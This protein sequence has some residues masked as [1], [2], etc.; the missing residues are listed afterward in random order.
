MDYFAAIDAATRGH[1]VMRSHWHFAWLVWNAAKPAM[2]IEHDDG[3]REPYRATIS[4]RAAVDWSI[5]DE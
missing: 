1:R 3:K 5:C 4:D 2:Q